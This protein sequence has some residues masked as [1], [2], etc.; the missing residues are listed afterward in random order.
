MVK[1]HLLFQTFESGILIR[2]IGYV[3]ASLE[4]AHEYVTLGKLKRAIT[5]FNQALEIVRGGGVSDDVAVRFLL[6]F[7]ESLAVLE[8]VSKR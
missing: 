8:D 3:N 2:T 6:R 7:A 1:A 5:I 4:L